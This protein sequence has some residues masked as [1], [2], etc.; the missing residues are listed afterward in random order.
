MKRK[1]STLKDH[2]QQA[3]IYSIA[4][5]AIESLA[6]NIGRVGQLEPCLITPDNIL[7]SGYTRVA[8]LKHLGKK[9]CECRVLDIPEDEQVFYLISSNKQRVKDYVCRMAEI[10]ALGEY[11]EMGQGF[12]SDLH[13]ADPVPLEGTRRPPAIQLIANDL[14]ISKNTIHQLRYIRKQR[15]DLLPYIGKSITLAACFAQVKMWHNQKQVISLKKKQ[16]K[17][18]IYGGDG[19][20]IYRKPAEQMADV[21]EEN[22]VD[23]ILTSPPFFQQR[24]FD[25][26]TSELGQEATVEEYAAN[27]VNIFAEC[28]RVLKPTGSLYL[29]LGDTYKDGRKLQVPER[30]SLAIADEL[31]FIL[32]N[33]LIHN[34]GSSVAP[35]STKRRR[36]TDYEYWYFYCLDRKAY[37]YDVDTIRIPYATDDPV[38]RKA[39]R[40]YSDMYEGVNPR[41]VNQAE[42]GSLK[43]PKYLSNVGAS[44]RNDL[45]KVPGCILNYSRHANPLNLSDVEHTA[46][47]PTHLIRELLKPVVRSGDVVMDCFSGSATTGVVAAEFGASYIGFEINSQFAELGQK[48][49]KQFLK[50]NK[51]AS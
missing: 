47:F 21:L 2:P 23:V 7:I 13:S 27:L 41:W 44:L 49:M 5:E 11:Y 29:N 26:H 17:K 3:G 6:E 14:G 18:I 40:H 20:T 22:S 8:A 35:E 12:R 43:D 15:G 25:D 32:R 19:F 31:G 1:I 9:T 38:D 37:Y 42:D 46:P 39:P 51:Q 4:D 33:T 45:G 48:R 36:H 50:E 24:V 34:K 16:S 10:D 28:E 30:V